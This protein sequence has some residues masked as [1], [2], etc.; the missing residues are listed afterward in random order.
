MLFAT[1]F[2]TVS[3]ALASSRGN[4]GFLTRSTIVDGVFKE[5]SGSQDSMIGAYTSQLQR[6]IDTAF[7]P[8]NATNWNAHSWI[9]D[10]DLRT[11]QLS[12]HYLADAPLRLPSLFVLRL[13]GTLKPAPNISLQNISRFTAMVEMKDVHFSAV[14]GGR[15]DASS[16]PAVNGSRGW[17][18]ISIVGSSHC[19]IRGVRALANNSD[20]AIGLNLGGYHEVSFS[21]VGG[22]SAGPRTRGRAI[23]TL[24]TSHNLIHDN[25]I[26]N[27]TSHSLDFDAY[28]GDS[29]AY[30]NFCEYC[31]EEGIFVEE[32]AHDNTIFNNTCSNNGNGI[33][34]YSN[35]VGPVANNKVCSFAQRCCP[36][37]RFMIVALTCGNC[38]LL[39]TLYVT[40]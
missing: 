38:R 32:T 20:S 12:G 25:H 9:N 11:L 39:A 19:A 36:G 27:S 4:S 34:L 3:M 31:T 30:N 22:D 29:L 5:H 15:Y 21:D 6:H 40:I 2:S 7:G 10:T 17:Q 24:A 1:A 14:I 26:H 8:V 23:W 13:N 35:A 18:S 37:R 33:G 16:L 28:T